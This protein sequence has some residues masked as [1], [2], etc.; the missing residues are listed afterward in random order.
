ML[1]IKKRE[2]VQ[3]KTMKKKV[4]K[5]MYWKAEVDSEN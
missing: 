2:H 3:H 1:A 4:K 5:I